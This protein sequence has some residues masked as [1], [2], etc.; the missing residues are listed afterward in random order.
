MELL[1]KGQ[2][3]HYARIMPTLGLYDVYDCKIITIRDTWFSAMEKRSKR[4][5]IFNFAD[6][7]KIVF[8]NRFDAVEKVKEAES[9]KNEFNVSEE[10]YYEE[11]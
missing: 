4:T 11:D 2:E 1:K 9:H 10:T 6:I 3:V 5:F 7:G 8:K